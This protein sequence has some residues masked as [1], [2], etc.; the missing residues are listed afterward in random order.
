MRETI[1]STWTIQ[2]MMGFIFL[3]VSFL[4]V[5]ISYSKAFKVKNEVTS[6]IEK[7]GG[8]NTS[9]IKIIN[10]YVKTSSYKNKGKC[11]YDVGDQVIGVSQLNDTTNGDKISSASAGGYYYC[12]KKETIM[13]GTISNTYYEITMFYK[14]N[15]PV[16]GNIATFKVKGKTTDMTDIKR[17]LF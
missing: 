11:P 16:M 4:A 13:N 3:F 12:V 9:S 10:N 1:G 2:L 17:D 7:Y 8:F 5:T 6:I 15:L 14:F